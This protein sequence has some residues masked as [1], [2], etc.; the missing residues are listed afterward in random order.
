MDEKKSHGFKMRYFTY[1][2][3]GVSVVCGS[4]FLYFVFRL[5]GVYDS[6]LSNVTDYT[7]STKAISEFR[8]SSDFLTNQARLFAAKQDTI[9]LNNYLH[10]VENLKTRENSI[11]VIKMTHNQDDVITNVTMAYNESQYIQSIELYAM[12]ITCLA[13]GIEVSKY[14]D[15]L[16]DIKEKII[17][18]SRSKNIFGLLLVLITFA[19]FVSTVPSLG[20]RF[21]M[22]TYPL[23]AYILLLCIK[24]YKKMYSLL[25]AFVPLYFF[26]R[27]YQTLKLY[28]ETLNIDFFISSPI[29][30]LGKY[31]LF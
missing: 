1:S 7:E 2:I 11:D 13:N 25:I 19:N 4:L 12:K 15:I 3:L 22:F 8:D 18:D 23:I 6:F 5:I 24:D 10:E 28:I 31:L 20:A 30:L 9:F 17:K 16:N 14:G 27:I 21:V 29:Y 26:M